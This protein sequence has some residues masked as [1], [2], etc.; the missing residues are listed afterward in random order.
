M[1]TDKSQI[2]F[3]TQDALKCITVTGAQYP[4]RD[5]KLV[6][7]GEDEAVLTEAVRERQ[8]YW[9]K[10]GLQDYFR[11]PSGYKLPEGSKYGSGL[12]AL[13]QDDKRI[14]YTQEDV[15]GYHSRIKQFLGYKV[16][17]DRGKIPASPSENPMIKC[18]GPDKFDVYEEAKE[19]F[20]KAVKDCNEALAESK[21]DHDEAVRNANAAYS[22]DVAAENERFRN[23]E[24]IAAAK[25]AY[26]NAVA[27]ADA[28]READ[29][30]SENETHDDNR[31]SILKRFEDGEIDAK[32]RDLLLSEEDERHGFRL[33]EIGNAYTNALADAET[34]RDLA[35]N[36][37]TNAH[38]DKLAEL[39]E[40]R[41]TA[42]GDADEEYEE[43]QT[44]LKYAR[45]AY[46]TEIT[47]SVP[48]MMDRVSGGDYSPAW[49]DRQA[50][51][52]E[53]AITKS[54]ADAFYARYALYRP[55]SDAIMGV[56]A[57]LE[58]M[59][60]L[61]TAID[62]GYLTFWRAAHT[63]SYQGES[64]LGDLPEDG[65][66]KS[67]A[68][69]GWTYE[70][71]DFYFMYGQR[72]EAERV[73]KIVADV[74][75]ERKDST[76][77]QVEDPLI[78]AENSVASTMNAAVGRSHW[79]FNDPASPT[80]VILVD[81]S[82]MTPEE[83]ER[84]N[85]AKEEC[86]QILD[87]A[88]AE[89]RETY[90]YTRNNT[91]C[92]TR[93]EFQ[94]DSTPNKESYEAIDEIC[95]DFMDEMRELQAARDKDLEDSRVEYEKAVAKAKQTR[96][97]AIEQAGKRR[98]DAYD[99]ANRQYVD[100]LWEMSKGYNTRIM[101]AETE[102]ERRS[103]LTDFWSASFGSWLAR[104]QA[105]AQADENLRDDTDSAQ[106]E[107]DEA[108]SNAGD[109]RSERNEDI[110][111]R[112]YKDFQELTEEKSVLVQDVYNAHY[113]DVKAVNDANTQA[114]AEARAA[115]DEVVDNALSQAEETM[116]SKGYGP[117]VETGDWD[118]YGSRW[119]WVNMTALTYMIDWGRGASQ[120]L[121]NDA[122]AVNMQI[123]PLQEAAVDAMGKA[124]WAANEA[125][126][127]ALKELP[128]ITPMARA[129][130]KATITP[131]DSGDGETQS[132]RVK[133]VMNIVVHYNP[134][135]TTGADFSKYY[136]RLDEDEEEE[137][138][139]GS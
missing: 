96:D 115:F 46:I 65:I 33:Q 48:S 98:D 4:V 49:N 86:D 99:A 8:F 114:K 18:S 5:Q 75:L 79:A 2:L 128:D 102:A 58:H 38:Y 124:E 24:A 29:D 135:T 116:E 78:A 62:I 122:R 55:A 14:L 3:L 126:Y 39:K 28:T 134:A 16:W 131:A 66:G 26:N 93:V 130:F 108:E 1:I 41:D 110:N 7:L 89:R 47:E 82:S 101:E 133:D 71:T 76:P 85:R 127:E 63:S 43:T 107:Y 92:V 97:D 27:A 59:D 95:D 106:D 80:Y 103:I 117:P 87:D 31:K 111:E 11:L 17:L 139:N 15:S 137:A 36:E 88:W 68:V 52:A 12:L 84:G 112:Y 23:D 105:K 121:V 22:R 37:A 94:Y 34:E 118:P 120:S 19:K 50:E 25:E 67:V 35:V 13:I 104:E 100:T 57:D 73:E 64:R 109:E 51:F 6:L 136:A 56:Y 74:V 45:D 54:C 44:N 70:N 32:E 61:M 21:D 81:T 42:V 129:R 40:T 69:T 60:A 90:F 125:R 30:E 72:Y 138:Q 91:I 113:A 9:S 10:Y 119:R 20:N 77:P 132:V 83:L 123:I 53:A